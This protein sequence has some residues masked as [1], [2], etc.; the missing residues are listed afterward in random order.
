MSTNTK[1]KIPSILK[2]YGD[3]IGNINFSTKVVGTTFIRDNNR[4]LKYLRDNI[5]KDRVFLSLV[6]E[7]DNPYDSNAVRVEFCLSDVTHTCF[8][9]SKKLGYIPRNSTEIINYV[10]NNSRDYSID[11]Y[12]MSVVG[13]TFNKPNFGMY[14]SYHIFRRRI[15]G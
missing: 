8:S 1:D 14:F 9:N 6:Q 7:P 13:G 15:D 3:N 11:I 5:S 4:V 10:L 2:L 12:D